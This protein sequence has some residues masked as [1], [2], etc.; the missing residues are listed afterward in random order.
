MKTKKFKKLAKLIF[1]E[2]EENNRKNRY[3]SD[4]I[5]MKEEVSQSNCEYDKEVSDKFF[6]F[7]CNLMKLK[8]YLSIYI[9]DEHISINGDLDRATPNSSMSKYNNE[10]VI[11]IR[12]DKTGFRVRRSY[13]NYLNYLDSDMLEKLKPMLIEKNKVISKQIILDTID[14]IMVKTNLSR[15][16][17]LDELLKG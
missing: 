11:E 12:V 6:N 14:D 4:T 2:V 7:V 17:N 3:L 5:P 10:D 9:Y 13:G 1:D 16:N 8:T 15:E